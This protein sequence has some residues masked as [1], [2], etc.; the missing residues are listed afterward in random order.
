[1]LMLGDAGIRHFLVA[2]IHLRGSLEIAIGIMR[3]EGYGTVT[4]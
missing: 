3:F 1:M 2:E 4:K